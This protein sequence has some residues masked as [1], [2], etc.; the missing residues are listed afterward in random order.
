[1]QG[2]ALTRL[3]GPNFINCLILFHNIKPL[4]TDDSLTCAFAKSED[5]DEMPNSVTFCKDK[6]DLQRKKIFLF[7]ICTVGHESDLGQTVCM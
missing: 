4:Y 3:G 1:M 6:N 7:V 5:P 2:N